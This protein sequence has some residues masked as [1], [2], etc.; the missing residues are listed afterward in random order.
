MAKA[1]T[2]ST[3][4]PNPSPQASLEGKRLA[5]LTLRRPATDGRLHHLIRSLSEACG[6]AAHIIDLRNKK[7]GFSQA[8][9]PTSKAKGQEVRIPLSN[10]Q[11]HTKK[12]K[13]KPSTIYINSTD[14]QIYALCNRIIYRQKIWVDLLEN[15]VTNLLANGRRSGLQLST[16]LWIARILQ[17]WVPWNNFITVAEECFYGEIKFGHAKPLLLTHEMVDLPSVEH[18]TGGIADLP[19][20]LVTGTLG[21]HYGTLDALAWSKA[22]QQKLPH[23]LR[24][25]GHAPDPAF[26]AELKTAAVS[27]PEIELELYENYRPQEIILQEMAAATYLLC[28]YHISPATRNRIP[29]KFHEAAHTGCTLIFPR[30][31]SWERWCRSR[32]LP[33]MELESLSP[34][35]GAGR[36]NLR[37]DWLQQRKDLQ[38]EAALAGLKAL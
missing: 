7:Q 2:Y 15:D 12:L 3:T 22:A 8:F 14:L 29:T 13:E 21:R 16:Y 11:N 36:K 26:A 10:T 34:S 28:P 9:L 35:P 27:Y 24:I 6:Y 38:W 31:A 19:V 1:N 18:C 25:V 23:T 32:N 17:E 30:N 37:Q 33:Y 4:G 20:V 5:I